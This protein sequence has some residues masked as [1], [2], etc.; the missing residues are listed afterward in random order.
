M[1]VA[2]LHCIIGVHVT[3][4]KLQAC[5]GMFSTEK[6]FTTEHTFCIQL[7]AFKIINVFDINHLKVKLK[8]FLVE[9]Y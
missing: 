4:S 6:S 2:S 5:L 3:K 8:S 9:V 1:G 7:L